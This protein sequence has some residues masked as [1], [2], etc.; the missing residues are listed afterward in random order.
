MHTATFNE[1]NLPFVANATY[2]RTATIL[3]EKNLILFGYS[4]AMQFDGEEAA[5]QT[6]TI[7]TMNLLDGSDYKEVI[8]TVDGE[9]VRNLLCCNNIGV[10]N[11][12]NIWFCGYVNTLSTT[13]VV[14]YKVDNLETGECS[15]VAELLLPAD[16]ASAADGRMDY[17][18]IIGDITG[19]NA[20]CTAMWALSNNNAKC[21]RWVREQGSDEWVGGYDTFVSPEDEL[22]TYPADQIFGTSCVRMVIDDEFSGA[23][24]YVDGNNTCPGLYDIGTLDMIESFASVESS[25]QPNVAPCGVAEFRF[26]EDYYMIYA[27]NQP[28][29]G[30]TSA[31][32]CV[33]KLGDGGTFEG[34]EEMWMLPAENG[35]GDSN[36]GVR[37]HALIIKE[38][39]DADGKKGLYLLS[40]KCNNGVAVYRIAQEGFVDENTH[41]VEGIVADES[42]A[43]VEYYNIQGMKIANPENG[44]YI[45]VQGNKATKVNLV[46]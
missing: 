11:F 32:V 25:L 1:A 13:P 31:E 42:N 3:P 2:V 17:V 23:M 16:E 12:G 44:L 37:Y 26:D 28:N 19:E 30:L 22:V 34:M 4:K 14:L 33:V 29:A 43:P 46:K 8:L 21:H 9:Y 36:D 41:G 27:R 18:D 35:F 24:Y 6:A 15:K 40:Y 5:T 45:K 39:T 38:I 7:A 20:P 10:D